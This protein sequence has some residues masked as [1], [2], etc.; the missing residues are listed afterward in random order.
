MND[1]NNNKLLK[2]LVNR[3]IKV[4]KLTCIIKNFRIQF[5]KIIKIILI[6]T[7][8]KM[9]SPPK[10]M[11]DYLNKAA[12]KQRNQSQAIGQTKIINQNSSNL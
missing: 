9:M 2:K 3:I 8:K 11:M 7:L 10:T 1:K 4:I 6:S 5:N 12:A